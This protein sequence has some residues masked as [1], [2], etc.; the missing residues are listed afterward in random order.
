MDVPVHFKPPYRRPR[1]PKKP[2]VLGGGLL[3][4]ARSTTLALLGVTTAVGLSMVALALN[5]SW[6][7]VA[8]SPIPAA[9][10]RH[11][12]VGKATIAAQAIAN[13]PGSSLVRAENAARPGSRRTAGG[14]EGGGAREPEGGSAP[15]ASAELV[16][17]PSAPAEPQ[18]N[19]PRGTAEPT[20]SPPPG[21][22]TPEAPAITVPVSEPTQPEPAPQSPP[23]TE[24]PPATSS[25]APVDSSDD[26]NW[27]DDDDWDDDDWDDHDDDWDDHGGRGH[28]WSRGHHDD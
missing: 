10:L 15:S 21:G 2:S 1:S 9:P 23:M 27:D 28:H 19:T 5:Q 13:A 24:T 8:D 17:A 16:V 3:E 26:D 4:R 11:E 25:E 7:L 14:G 18:G 22:T 6:P 20:P 12:K